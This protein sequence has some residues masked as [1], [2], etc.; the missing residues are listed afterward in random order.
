MSSAGKLNKRIDLLRLAAVSDG[1]GG[2]SESF[3]AYATVWAEV[4]PLAQREKDQF[5]RTE[6]ELT[7]RVLI[8]HRDDVKATDRVQLG[9]RVFV[10]DG[11]PVN[12]KERGA[13][14]QLLCRE[15]FDN[16]A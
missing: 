14:L 16:G 12:I 11:P 4:S 6:S 13:F 5:D 1:E 9:S 2:Y 7:H 10:Q 3:P 8:R 15:V